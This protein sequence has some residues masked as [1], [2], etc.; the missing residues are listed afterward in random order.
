[1]DQRGD[2]N[3]DDIYQYNLQQQQDIHQAKP[4]E[5]DPH[6]FREVRISA[7]ALLKMVMHARS[8]GNLEVMGLLMGKV[9]VNTM[10]AM[11]SFA[12]PVEGTETRVNAQAQAYEYMAAFTES[13]KQ[14][15]RLENVI[16]WYHSHPG[17][18][19]WLSGID[20]N[21]QMLNQQFQEPWVAIVIDPVR[22][23]S[24]G[25]VNLGAFRTYPKAYKPPDEGPSE[26]QTIPLNKIEDFGVHC[27]QY[28]ALDVTYFKSSLDHKLLD[29][30][31]NNYW[32]HT[33][34]SSSLLAPAHSDY[35]TGQILDLADKLEHAEHQL[36]RGGFMMGI[37]PHEK[38]LEDK[39]LKATND[40]CKTTIEALNG[41]M[42]QIVKDTLFNDLIETLHA[43]A[44]K[45]T[46][47]QASTPIK[48]GNTVPGLKE[49]SKSEVAKNNSLESGGRVW[50][51][52]KSG[53]YDIT[54]FI[55]HHPGG[56]K[57][58]LGAG[59][60]IEPFWNLYAVHKSDQVFGMLESYRI[61]NLRPEDVALN[62]QS[63]VADPYAGDPVRPSYFSVRSA[64]PFNAEP[65][66]NIL[67]DSWITPNEFFYI[68]NHLPVPEIDPTEYELEIE[69]FNAEKS[70]NLSLN[71]LK[72]KFPKYSITAAIQCAG[73]RRSEM[74]KVKEV[75][76]LFWGGAAISNAQWSGARL[77]DVLRFLGID[78]NDPRIKHV[79]FEGSDTDATG[80]PY[81]ASIPVDL[82]LDERNQV[83]LAY[84][85]N[86][87]DIPKDHGYPV[88]LVAPGIVGARNVKWLSKIILS[89]EESHSFWQRRD[90]KGFSPNVDWSNVDFDSAP[91]IQ[92]LPVQSA[93]CDPLDGAIVQPGPDG[94]IT[95]RGYAWSGAGRKIVRV[96]VSPDGGSTWLT[97]DLE[98]E[99]GSPLNR[100]WSWTLWKIKVPVKKGSKLQVICKAID[101]CY[102]N[103]PENVEPIWNL[104]GVLTNSW[105][106]ISL[107]VS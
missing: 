47:K 26:Y 34:S 85:M 105:H 75:K 97:A 55:S 2:G 84:E 17:Y 28:Y 1:M 43:D 61:G 27:K 101:S 80:N 82:A 98:Q 66:L 6:Y 32:V 52:F 41:L 50:V 3:V 40:C 86:G 70:F 63:E 89:D 16:G 25:K 48:Y 7:L 68:R 35:T 20:V 60:D 99:P 51:I 44:Q 95:V 62:D 83:L 87:V 9:E 102:N 94:T 107:E 65:P 42:A 29:S 45:E 88:R 14:V 53:V 4:W 91:S 12:L 93:I 31:W 15:G 11:D 23:I 64:K 67:V 96:D 72:T 78:L 90:Y 77:C 81:G 19:C 79:Q 58:L 73:N 13:A 100:T 49:Y 92:E 24:S 74:T 22:T 104:R 37:D 33:L 54:E 56:D 38:R 71:D 57:I 21:T 5:K 36:Q 76:G 18:G 8:G 10:I 39:L 106:R 59:G 69:G 46:V 103:Q 30:L